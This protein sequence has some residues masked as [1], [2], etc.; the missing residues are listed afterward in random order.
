M[1]RSALKKRFVFKFLNPSLE[2]GSLNHLGVVLIR[3]H[4]LQM[5]DVDA[6]T[7]ATHVVDVNTEGWRTIE[8][9]P[10]SPIGNF[11]GFG[12]QDAFA[13]PFA[14]SEQDVHLS[15]PLRLAYF[16]KRSPLL[17]VERLAEPALALLAE[18]FRHRTKA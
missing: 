3:L 18:L 16:A 1:D 11:L 5:I 13:V 10:H 6:S 8:P 2:T 9:G 14:F 12:V 4:G 7:V 17:I 15:V